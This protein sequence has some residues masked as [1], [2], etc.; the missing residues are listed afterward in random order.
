[1]VWQNLKKSIPKH[2]LFKPL[3]NI[4]LVFNFYT[5]TASYTTT[6]DQR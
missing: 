4:N 3:I 2:C 1:M 6:F 5:S